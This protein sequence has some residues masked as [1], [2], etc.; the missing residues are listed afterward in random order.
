MNRNYFTFFSAS[1]LM[2]AFTF[3]VVVSSRPTNA[4]EGRTL[5]RLFW[6]DDGE[7]SLR[8]GDLQKS[9]SGWS[10]QSNPIEG[11][12]SLDPAEQS[13]VQM[14]SD[15]GLVLLGIHDR[16]DGSFGSGW[17]AIES[18]VVEEPHGD[19]S[20]WH[21]SDSPRVVKQA[22]D[23]EQGNPAHVYKY[24]DSFVMAN[25]KLNGFTITSAVDLRSAKSPGQATSFHPGGNGHITLGVIP[26]QV[27][28]ATWIARDGDD[29]GRVDVV[30]LGT[31]GGKSY[32][33]HCPTGGLHGA[34]A[35]SGKVF[36][37]PTDGI[38]WVNADQNVA[39]SSDSVHVHHLPLGNDANDQPLRTGA[40]ENL[41]QLVL[42]T[43]GKGDDAKLCWIDASADAPVVSTLPIK[44]DE[45]ES[46]STP[47]AVKARAGVK[48]ALLFREN[49]DTP[50]KDTLVFVDLDPNG[51]G[52]HEDAV[53]AKTIAIGRNQIAGHSGHHQV[54]SLPRGREVAFT[55]PADGTVTIVSLSDFDKT[56]TINVGGKPTRLIAIGG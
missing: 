36:F 21:F 7:P 38:C 3:T 18:G 41:D 26:Q 32:S 34:T 22:V 27:A 51:D 54:I 19:H 47:T 11:F 35:N 37:A 31:N 10:L 39:Q 45:G 53:I 42:F 23:A 2:M 4:A 25:D 52:S 28:Y 29:C 1:T 55:N 46:L 12:P 40:F 13:L 6:Q 50:E 5:A 9:A 33:F 20:H 8:Y 49:R 30:G 16:A 14:Q 44:L 15:A 17:V 24:G 56:T 43:A 48:M